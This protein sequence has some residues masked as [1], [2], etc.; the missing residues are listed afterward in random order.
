LRL[1]VLLGPTNCLGSETESSWSDPGVPAGCDC[2]TQHA[3]RRIRT[4]TPVVEWARQSTARVG[5][6]RAAAVGVPVHPASS[7]YPR[8]PAGRGELLA[9]RHA[10]ALLDLCVRASKT[11][12]YICKVV[13]FVTQSLYRYLRGEGG[14]RE[15]DSS[16]QPAR[17]PC[18]RSRADL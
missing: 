17:S 16:P 5:S 8:G 7:S 10:R 18:S 6:R 4:R 3:C 14:E 1:E 12:T 13:M 2:S 15:K 9:R 11:P